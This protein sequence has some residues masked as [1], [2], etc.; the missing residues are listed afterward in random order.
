MNLKKSKR[1][2]ILTL[3]SVICFVLFF[4]MALFFAGRGAYQGAFE[5]ANLSF[6]VTADHSGTVIL[7]EERS[8]SLPIG[9]NL[10]LLKNDENESVSCSL[11]QNGNEIAA[12]TLGAKEEKGI[13]VDSDGG[14]LSL[15]LQKKDEAVAYLSDRDSFQKIS[16]Q[17]KNGGDLVFLAPTDIGRA[18]LFA[19][20]RLFGAFS[21]RELN[22]ES[23]EE[24]RIVLSP[25]H[26]FNGE[27]YV[28]APNTR[29][30]L[31]NFTP[32]FSKEDRD[33]YLKA[34]SVNGKPLLPKEYPISSYENLL[35]LSSENEL[36]YLT[37]GATLRF[38]QALT[39]EKSLSFSILAKLDFAKP[40]DFHG[41]TLTFSSDKEGTYE[42]KTSIGAGIDATS[43]LFEAPRARLLWTGE[44]TIPARSTV[45]K[46]SNL[47]TYNGEDLP[48]GGEGKAIPKLVLSA[49]G[50]KYLTED[51]VFQVKGNLLVASLPYLTTLK[52]LDEEYFA[53]SCE[54]GTVTVQGSILDG[55]VVTKDSEGKE[56]RFL[57]AAKR[58]PYQI[59]VVHLET[60][61]GA[62]I[63]SKSQH[64]SGT[65]AMDGSTSEYESLPETH[66]RIRGRGNSSWKWDKKPY[67]IHFDEPTSLLGLPPAEEWALFSNYADKSLMRNRLAQVMAS[68]LSFE[69]CPTQVCVDV[70]L[71]GEYLGVY[72]LGEHLEAGDGR[73]EVDY[74]MSRTDCGYFLE[75][76]GVVSGVDVKGMNYFHAG[77]VKF[78]LIKTPEYNTLTSEQFEFIHQYMLRAD[79]AVKS[80]ENYEDYL[81]VDSV[82]DWL[83][84]I[85]LSCN[86][87]CSWRRSTYFTK[88]PGGK[89]VMGPVWDFD[90]AFG[91]FSKDNPGDDTWV[92][93]EPD[94]DY[95][96]ETWS[97]YLLKDPEF[98][99]RFKARWQEVRDVLVDTAMEEIEKQYQLNSASAELNFKRWDI[100]GKKVAFE[101]HDT[102]NYRTY[103]SQIY[104]LED[105]ITNRASWIDE[106][107]ATFP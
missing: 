92:S 26:P 94:D 31:K 107:V 66:I 9:Q 20:F 74:D 35:R 59:P 16:R 18:E 48:L 103:S 102:K 36:P 65:F 5:K 69:Y 82:I 30:F 50:S 64:V 90:L 84:M 96:G 87:D 98:Q 24:G 75:A 54:D 89:L 6:S 63:T 4:A 72:T 37:D 15:L 33:F 14:A 51:A 39:L 83:I 44:G 105:F 99:A 56:R 1:L 23:K 42:V 91:N 17:M 77:L 45:A 27:L 8:E 58:D 13:E 43:L 88:E 21:F 52:N 57:V 61:N 80:G 38:N 22:V 95:V 32:S 53:L 73:V 97:T 55:I 12:L 78:V 93:S 81:D 34:K 85:E 86:T 11:Y 67:K 68:E 2:L 7:S 71:N 62:E 41:N 79:E 60:E 101:R 3:A 76:G 49:E 70:F 40:V 10:L 100:L 104:Y 25:D 46:A 19:P 106:Q 28:Y 47:N 29:I